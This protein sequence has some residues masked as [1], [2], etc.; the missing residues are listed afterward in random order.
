MSGYSTT[1]VL[2]GVPMRKGAGARMRSLARA[3]LTLLVRNRTA[4]FTALLM[5]L[6]MVA[7]GYSVSQDMADDLAE[8][9]LSVGMTVASGGLVMIML[10][11]VYSNLT[12]AYAARREERVLK[13]L[14]TGEPTDGEILAGMALPSVLLALAQC[15]LLVTATALLMADSV[16]RQPLPL[17]LGALLGCV[18]MAVAAV[19][20]ASFTRNA[21]SAQITAVPLFL[22]S[23]VPVYVPLELLPD[24]LADVL[25]LLPLTPSLELMRSGWSG[26]LDGTEL[27]RALG[28]AVVLDGAGGV[29]CTPVVPLGAPAVNRGGGER[30]A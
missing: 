10:L 1:S 6:L 22:V 26:G 25:R 9:G 15:V 14:R 18:L 4:L 28:L 27:L 12:A 20:T 3:E 24:T 16:P 19:V 29:C 13:R 7:A 30:N 23:A 8:G 11:V 17:A 2:L 5:P 21:E